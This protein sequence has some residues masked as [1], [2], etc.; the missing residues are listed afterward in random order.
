MNKILDSTTDYKYVILLIVVILIYIY[1]YT[2]INKNT[3]N[4]YSPINKIEKFDLSSTCPGTGCTISYKGTQPAQQPDPTQS[5]NINY[6][7]YINIGAFYDDNDGNRTIPYRVTGGPNFTVSSTNTNEV[8]IQ[9]C[10]DIARLYNAPIF[11]IQNSSELYL[12]Y[13]MALPASK[14]KATGTT[15]V[16]GRSNVNQVYVIPSNYTYT[17]KAAYKDSQFRCIPFLIN[18]ISAETLRTYTTDDAIKANVTPIAN[19]YRATVFGL[20]NNGQLFI[21]YDVAK[22]TSLGTAPTCTALLGCGWVNQVYV[23]N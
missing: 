14:G 10:I 18:D 22:A 19:K 13:N 11:G 12:G 6:I 9:K 8:I 4:Y 20:Q 23:I 16:L 1:Y 3:N 5:N 2:N 7:Y 15:G 21:G 17:Y